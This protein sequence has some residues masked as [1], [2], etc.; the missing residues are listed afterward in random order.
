MTSITQIWDTVT[1]NILASPRETPSVVAIPLENVDC[2][3]E[4]EHP[5]EAYNDYFQVTINQLF[6][7]YDRK[8]LTTIDPLVLVVSEFFYNKKMQEIPYIVGPGLVRQF[9]QKEPQGMLFRNEKVAGLHS[10]CGGPLTLSVVLCQVPV[11]S[12]AQP[13]LGVLERAT[14][15][16]DLATAVTSYLSVGKVILDGIEAILGLNGTLP[17]VG[18]RTT[19]NAQGGDP[20]KPNYFALIDAQNVKPETLKVEKNQLLHAATGKPYQEADFVLYSLMRAPARRRDDYEQLPFYELWER[21]VREATS[22]KEGSWDNAKA[23]LITLLNNIYLS[24]DLTEPQ[25][26]ELIEKYKTDLVAMHQSAIGIANLSDEEIKQINALDEVRLMAGSI[27][28][29]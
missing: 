3:A 11:G 18:L 4:M 17:L 20:P 7:K 1:Q 25:A 2:R 8:W 15:L 27:L 26:L 24:P 10:Y 12:P 16:L 5:F 14:K 19:F 9:A 21:A 13:F 28:Q 23:N 29:S 22:L 6:L